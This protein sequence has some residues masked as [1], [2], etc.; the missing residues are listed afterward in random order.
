VQYL[1]FYRAEYL[2]RLF[3]GVRILEPVV[4]HTHLQHCAVLEA[5]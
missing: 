5:T 2:R 3:P 1:T 4:P